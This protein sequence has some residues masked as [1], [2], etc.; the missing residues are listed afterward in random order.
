MNN[1]Y[2]L[3]KKELFK[4]HIIKG[5]T[6]KLQM[7][8]FFRDKG[9]LEREYFKTH[10]KNDSM[11]LLRLFYIIYNLKMFVIKILREAAFD[12]NLKV[13]KTY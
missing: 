4:I 7:K 12:I 13:R 3:K 2:Q 5:L 11:I 9:F 8:K 6:N 1:L 10:Q